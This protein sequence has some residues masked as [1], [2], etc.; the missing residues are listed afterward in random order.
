M[1]LSD[2]VQAVHIDADECDEVKEMWQRNVDGRS[3][4]QAESHLRLCHFHR[5]FAMCSVG[6]SI[7]FESRTRPP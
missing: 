3:L 4:N 7:Y 1:K 2:Q 5:R 6:S